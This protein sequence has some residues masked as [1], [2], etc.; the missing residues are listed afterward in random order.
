MDMEMP[1]DSLEVGGVNEMSVVVVV[2]ESFTTEP[3]AS[4]SVHLTI[5]RSNGLV[6]VFTTFRVPDKDIKYIFSHILGR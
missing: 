1:Q 6:G 4:V 3:A 2:D 5:D